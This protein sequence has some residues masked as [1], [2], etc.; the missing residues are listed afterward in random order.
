MDVPKNSNVNKQLQ[1]VNATNLNNAIDAYGINSPVTNDLM[2][3]HLQFEYPQ[4]YNQIED[5]IS[6]VPTSTTSAEG[7]TIASK[8]YS[9][10]TNENIIIS[11]DNVNDGTYNV[12]IEDEDNGVTL[13]SVRDGEAGD[14]ATQVNSE[15]QLLPT[16]SRYII[17]GQ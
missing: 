14:A 6:K 16:I 4:S 15:N 2:I 7:T 11:V 5:F 13:Q 8:V 1:Q 9:P 10:L 12:Y 17:L 3:N